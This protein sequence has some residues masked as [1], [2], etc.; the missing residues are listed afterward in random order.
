MGRLE[1]RVTIEQTQASLTLTIG[2]L[3]FDER[4]EHGL[5]E[6]RP[7]AALTLACRS[8][9]ERSFRRFPPGPRP[10]SRQ[11]PMQLSR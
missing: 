2:N 5:P 3:C 9:S 8:G 1:R 10:S 4:G 7:D 6:S 11:R